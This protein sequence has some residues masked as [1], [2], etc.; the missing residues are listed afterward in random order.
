M[1]QLEL[2]LGFEHAPIKNC[3]ICGTAPSLESYE[4]SALNAKYLAWH[5]T[6]S[7]CG[8]H[9]RSFLCGYDGTKEG[10]VKKAIRTWNKLNHK[11]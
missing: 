10:C 4:G 7:G 5:I 6:C 8:H 11:E 2:D 9:S 1:Q 3:P